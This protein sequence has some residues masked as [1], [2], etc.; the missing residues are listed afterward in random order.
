MPGHTAARA[1]ADSLVGRYLPGVNQFLVAAC[2]P[3]T[4]AVDSCVDFAYY[5]NIL[6]IVQM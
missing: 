2:F 3:A 1:A 4:G 5:F 6:Q